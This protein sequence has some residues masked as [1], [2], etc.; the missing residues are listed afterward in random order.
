MPIG[1]SCGLLGLSFSKLALKYRGNVP[2][3]SFAGAALGS[4]NHLELREVMVAKMAAETVPTAA[5]QKPSE[6]VMQAREFLS[7]VTL[8]TATVLAFGVKFREH[9]TQRGARLARD[10]QTPSSTRSAASLV[11]YA[12]R[13]PRSAAISKAACSVLRR[14]ASPHASRPRARQ[15]AQP[16][17]LFPGAGSARVAAC[18]SAR[19]EQQPRARN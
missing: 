19:E 8:T 2:V 3:T 16:H 18:P 12:E 1:C 17:A 11:P 4:V 5:S 7:M 10:R 9:L 13:A 6:S 14:A 15:A